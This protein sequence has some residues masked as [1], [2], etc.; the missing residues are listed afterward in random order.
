VS[1]LRRELGLFEATTITV[2]SMIGS[3]IF[4]VPNLVAREFPDTT[5]I[6]AIWILGGLFSLAG[7]LTVAELSAMYPRSG[8]PYRFVKEAFGEG[9][10]F[11]VGWGYFLLAKAGIGAAVAY[12]FA[13]YLSYFIPLSALGVTLMAAWSLAALT[14]VNWLGVKQSGGLQNGLTVLKGVSLLALIGAAIVL[15]P[16]GPP[17]TTQLLA[18]G[19]L[20]AAFIAVLFSYNAWINATFVAEEV[21]DPERTLP[22][23][24]ALGVGIVTLLYVGAN[25]AYLKILG[26]AG[27]ASSQLVG[28][29]AAT[30]LLP[31][32]GAFIAAAVLVSTFGNLNGGLMTGARLPMAMSQ[33]GL[34][35][36]RLS[37]LSRSGTPAAALGLQMVASIVLVLTG[38]FQGIITFSIFVIWG[39]LLLVAVAIFKLRRDRPEAP[40]PY[41]V[42]GY[43]LTPA[44]FV[45]AAGFVVVQTL[46][47]QPLSAAYGIGIVLTGVPVYIWMRRRKNRGHGPAPEG[48][49][50]RRIVLRPID[51]D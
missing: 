49:A 2:G 51:E 32:G 11:F 14:F 8:G 47:D 16:T 10:A 25:L 27:V 31:L 20:S 35:P 39:S 29:D 37:S 17:T 1:G 33:D 23:A 3:G 12:V 46:I 22:K 38:T 5:T 18:G 21:K 40:R 44:I 34:L 48:E 4:F 13:V 43:P 15:V 30:M 50:G 41:R 9:A 45:F 42:V 28:T 7:A 6:L 19:S 24:L 26:P 36:G